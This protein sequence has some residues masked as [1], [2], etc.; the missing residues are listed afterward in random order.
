MTYFCKYQEILDVPCMSLFYDFRQA[1]ES[2]DYEMCQKIMDEF[3]RREK[4]NEI[5]K[6]FM[7]ALLGFYND[8]FR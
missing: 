5:Y 6:E 8:Y 3:E 4:I 2:E 7:K 1:L